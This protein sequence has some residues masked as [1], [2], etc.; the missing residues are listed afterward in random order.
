MEAAMLAQSRDIVGIASVFAMSDDRVFIQNTITAAVHQ[1]KPNDNGGTLCGWPFATAR[2][3]GP[4][5]PYRV[6]PN[7]I[8]IPWH[9]LCDTCLKTE[10]SVAFKAARRQQAELSPD[11]CEVSEHD[12]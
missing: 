2:R 11:E 5:K 9:M 1:A 3:K 12:L 10:R 6:V 7:L 4:G 8:D